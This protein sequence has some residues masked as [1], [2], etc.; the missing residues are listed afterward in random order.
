MGGP[1]KKNSV[2]ISIA[3]ACTTFTDIYFL[4]WEPSLNPV[5]PI[6]CVCID[7]RKRAPKNNETNPQVKSPLRE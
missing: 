4:R 7:T 3:L 5:Y 6:Y 1:H 2:D